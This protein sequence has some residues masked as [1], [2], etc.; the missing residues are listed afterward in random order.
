VTRAAARRRRGSPSPSRRSSARPPPPRPGRG[1]RTEPCWASH[2]AALEAHLPNMASG[3]GVDEGYLRRA[4]VYAVLARAV[5]EQGVPGITDAGDGFSR[6]AL[7]ES[8]AQK[9]QRD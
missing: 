6:A 4:L 1:E 2:G 9:D 8:W 3:L 7:R 5:V